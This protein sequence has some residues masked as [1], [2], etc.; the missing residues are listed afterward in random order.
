MHVKCLDLLIFSLRNVESGESKHAETINY[1]FATH[2][3]C[4]AA[5][6]V[7]SGYN[8][9]SENQYSFTSLSFCFL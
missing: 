9:I 5:I 1:F 8:C 2:S 7:I 4:E 6:L 3:N